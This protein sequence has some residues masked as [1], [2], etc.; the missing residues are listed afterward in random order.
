MTVSTRTAVKPPLFGFDAAVIHTDGVPQFALG[1]YVE[2]SDGTVWRY[3][4]TT[5][6]LYQGSVYMLGTDWTVGDDPWYYTASPKVPFALGVMQQSI[7]APSGVTY[8]YCW[9][10]TAGNFRYIRI[11]HGTTKENPLSLSSAS[12][13]LT[14]FITPTMGSTVVNAIQ[15]TAS[16]AV[17]G[18]HGTLSAL[19]TAF[20]P[21]EL[22]VPREG[23]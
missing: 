13:A 4:R 18:T 10:Q 9:I 20:S 17:V 22:F 2:C 6:A 16:S 1:T 19:S 14:S 23:Q 8:N 12:G 3:V 5:K 7:A 21:V 15:C 11:C